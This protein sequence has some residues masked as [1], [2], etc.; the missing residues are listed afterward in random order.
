MAVCVS[1]ELERV[2]HKKR[3][4][5]AMRRKMNESQNTDAKIKI[6]DHRSVGCR[7]CL[8]CAHEG[9]CRCGGK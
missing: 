8:A 2:L 3:E 6:V 1:K 9:H 4:E 5:A 7:G